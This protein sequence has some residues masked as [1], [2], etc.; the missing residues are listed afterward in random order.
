[1]CIAFQVVNGDASLKQ[2]APDVDWVLISQGFDDHC[3]PGTSFI[4]KG[5]QLEAIAGVE[6]PDP[7][8]LLAG[9]TFGDLADPSDVS[10]RKAR[11]S[12]RLT[13]VEYVAL[14]CFML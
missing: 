9:G 1:V 6:S 2:L 3:H 12:H 10:V 4:G 5:D 14:L 13:F 8:Y 7:L 11:V